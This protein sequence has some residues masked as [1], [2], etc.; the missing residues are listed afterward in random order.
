MPPEY[1]RGDSLSS[2]GSTGGTMRF[3]D[4]DKLSPLPYS[5][6]PGEIR[7]R[8]SDA[9]VGNERLRAGRV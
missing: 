9:C 3:Q 4:E 5:A 7:R 8:V 6:F 1:G 2:S